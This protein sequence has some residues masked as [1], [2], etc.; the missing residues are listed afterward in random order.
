MGPPALTAEATGYVLT[1]GATGYKV[2]DLDLRYAAPI[3]C[4][5]D[6]TPS[7]MR[8]KAEFR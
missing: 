4:R 2:A 8:E 3:R 1:T 6:A 7:G 5:L